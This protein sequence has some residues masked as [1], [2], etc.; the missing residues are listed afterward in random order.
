MGC[1]IHWEDCPALS[2]TE[3]GGGGGGVGGEGWVGGLPD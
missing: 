3:Q 2:V 1:G